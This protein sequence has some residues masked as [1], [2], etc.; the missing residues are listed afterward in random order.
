MTKYKVVAE[1][2]HV[3]VDGGLRLAY[4]GAPVPDGQ[5]PERLKHLLSTGLI[6]AVDDA[7]LAPNAA[8]VAEEFATTGGERVTPEVDSEQE[9]KRAAARAKLPADG[10][11]PDGRA[12]H[13]TWVEYAVSKGLSREES[14]K[15]SKDDLKAALANQ[16]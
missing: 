7:D 15:A 16:K 13:E 12:S 8:V 4:K 5:D 14:E 9:Q 11:A 2:A 3:K 6:A 1:A 10:S